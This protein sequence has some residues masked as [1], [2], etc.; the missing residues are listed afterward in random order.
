ME[1]ARNLLDSL[2]EN[3]ALETSLMRTPRRPG[4]WNC[5]T[6][7]LSSET[8]TRGSG[9]RKM[10]E[11]GPRTQ[12]NF[13][14]SPRSERTVTH[15]YTRSKWKQ[16]QSSRLTGH[17]PSQRIGTNMRSWGGRGQSSPFLLLLLEAN[18]RSCLE[19]G[20]TEGAL[21]RDP[22]CPGNQ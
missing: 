12:V 16:T 11:D 5:N 8:A 15:N 19:R 2:S 9:S 17:A 18:V 10:R 21:H 7:R 1:T 20:G 4:C 22:G 6:T 14:R 3:I 13:D